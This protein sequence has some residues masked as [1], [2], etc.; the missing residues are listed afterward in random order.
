MVESSNATV[1]I[2]VSPYNDDYGSNTNIEYTSILYRPSYAV[3]ARELNQTQAI[4]HEHLKRY[5][6]SFFEEGCHISNSAAFTVSTTVDSLKLLAN[7]YTFDIN[8]I[9]GIEFTGNTSGATI[10]VEAIIPATGSNEPTIIGTITSG[11]FSDDEWIDNANGFFSMQLINTDAQNNSSIC[12]IS[13]SIWWIRGKPL[14]APAQT[15]V[16]EAYSST[17]SFHIGLTLNEEI[18]DETEDVTLLDNSLGTPNYLAPGAHRYRNQL[19]LDKKV[20]TAKLDAI[21]DFFPFANVVSGS[22]NEGPQLNPCIHNYIKQ[23]FLAN[24]SNTVYDVDYAN[25]IMQI[26]RLN[27]ANCSTYTG[28]NGEMTWCITTNTLAVHDGTTAGGI[29]VASGTSV[30]VINASAN[31]TVDSYLSDY[32]ISGFHMEHD[33]TYT[34]NTITITSGICKDS[35]RSAEIP[36]TSTT[37]VNVHSSST[38]DNSTTISANSFYHIYAC[39]S[40]DMTSVGYLVGHANT[41]SPPAPDLT[42]SGY[43]FYRRIGTFRTTDNEKVFPFIHS[44]NYIQYRVPLTQ[45]CLVGWNGG[46]NNEVDLSSVL[47]NGIN[48]LQWNG[49]WNGVWRTYSWIPTGLKTRIWHPDDNWESPLLAP[50]YWN[51][52]NSGT[53][54]ISTRIF[55]YPHIALVTCIEDKPGQEYTKDF[56]CDE[57]SKVRPMH[58]YDTNNSTRGAEPIEVGTGAVWKIGSGTTFVYQFGVNGF[59]DYRGTNGDEQ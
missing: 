15:L 45:I 47:P 21:T 16:L 59:Y 56:Y 24:T 38:L 1:D 51:E 43:A 33:G 58:Y 49:H 17:P 52:V 44:G 9:S 55:D 27:G 32:E 35:T 20:L 12:S 50:G 36:I 2:S 39:G 13:D 42:G 3:Q 30:T 46:S 25:N 19:V 22:V 28:P 14:H 6:D 31:V 57:N 53:S 37:V 10:N 40:S 4:H 7:S 48:R 29:N 34:S 26:K 23:Q 54:L 11:P 5:G 8:T 18:I 41:T